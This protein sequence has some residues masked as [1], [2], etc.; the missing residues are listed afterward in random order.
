MHEGETAGKRKEVRGELE[1]GGY[2]VAPVTV[3]T[4]DFRFNRPLIEAKTDQQ[5]IDRLKQAYLAH[6]SEQLDYAEGQSQKVFGTNITQIL[7]LHAGIATATFLDDL[8]DLLKKRGYQFVS[9]P[10]ALK[11]P[12]FATKDT[13][14]GPLG[15]SFI[16]R[17]A[18]TKGLPYDSEHGLIKDPGVAQLVGPE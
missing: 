9:F 1:R 5:V 18:A 3:K 15:L 2:Q 7:W 11:D 10:D 13:Y 6:V 14:A 17:V 4:S 8:I 16:D 12:A